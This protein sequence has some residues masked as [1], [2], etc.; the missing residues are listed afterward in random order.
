MKPVIDTAI[1]S[2]KP[3]IRT[4]IPPTTTIGTN[5]NSHLAR[6]ARHALLRKPYHPRWSATITT[7]RVHPRTALH[8]T[9][10]DGRSIHLYRESAVAGTVELC[11]EDAGRKCEGGGEYEGVL[12]RVAGAAKGG[13]SGLYG[14]ILKRVEGGC[15]EY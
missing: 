2:L 9:P 12:K 7:H 8:N 1:E 5:V 4:S 10:A 3:F 15:A 14:E 6:L 11:A 13:G